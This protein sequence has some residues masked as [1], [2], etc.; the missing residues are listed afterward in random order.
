MKNFNS[1]SKA[2]IEQFQLPEEIFDLNNP[3][4]VPPKVEEEYFV[5]EAKELSENRVFEFFQY[6]K[7]FD[8]GWECVRLY[9]DRLH[10]TDILH[11]IVD[12]HKDLFSEEEL[13]PV[14]AVLFSENGHFAML[15]DAE[16]ISYLEG[17]FDN[18]QAY[19]EVAKVIDE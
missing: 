12:Y 1:F 8:E 16:G 5:S 6:I 2:L 11:F 19:I 7:R 15:N 9:I 13:Q 18:E 4:L 17:V 3:E 14:K 10:I